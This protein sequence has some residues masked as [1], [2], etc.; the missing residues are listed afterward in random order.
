MAQQ[1][2]VCPVLRED[3]GLVSQNPRSGLQLFVPFV[4]PVPGDLALS[5]DLQGRQALMMC[6]YTCGQSAPTHNIK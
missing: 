3:W 2:R 5:S 1:S 4:T 6:V